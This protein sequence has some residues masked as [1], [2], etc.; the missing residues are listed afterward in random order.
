M[1]SQLIIL[2]LLV[3]ISAF[4]A[5]SELAFVVAS[6]L[7]IE[8]RAR[9]GN[10]AAKAVYSFV[11]NPQ[12]FF[13][14]ILIANNVVNIA[15]ASLSALILSIAFN[16]NEFSILIISTLI[17]L[18]FGELLPKYFARELSDR[19]ILFAS[20]PIRIVYYVL[21]PFV[22]ITSLSLIDHLVIP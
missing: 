8:I 3:V 17:L 15:F 18:I 11:K 13:S 6:K 2:I 22:R 4:F 9:K 21:F 7:K 19:V 20:I 14:T 5:G 12:Y 10:I 1:T 16:L